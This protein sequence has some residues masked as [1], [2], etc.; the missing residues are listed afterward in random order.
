MSLPL[1]SPG[2]AQGR[3]N[4]DATLSKGTDALAAGD[5]LAAQGDFSEA[6]AAY[7]SG[8]SLQPKAI[9]L[10]RQKGSVLHAMGRIAEAL[11]IYDQLLDL[12]PT[13]IQALMGKGDALAAQQNP[14]ALESYGRA[15]GLR[16]N[17][18]G[19][20]RRNALAQRRFGLH[21]EALTTFQRA[22]EID[23]RDALSVRGKGDELLEL[24][25]YPEAF[26]AF[27]KTAE[28]VP[29]AMNGAEWSVRGEALLRA[30]KT[31]AALELFRIATSLEPSYVAAWS[32][33]ARAQNQNKQVAEALATLDRT[34]VNYPE[35]LNI[36]T[37]KGALLI[38]ERQFED[39]VSTYDAILRIDPV[40]WIGWANKG[41]ALHNLAR[42]EDANTCYDKALEL[43]PQNEEIWPFKGVCLEELGKPAE[44]LACY[45]HALKINPKSFV[46]LNNKGWLL[47]QQD[48]FELAL[49]LLDRAIEQNPTEQT[50]W[51]N[52]VFTLR[53]MG[54]IDEALACANEGIAGVED[55]RRLLNFSG[56]L[57]SDYKD[58]HEGA[59]AV[60]R[61]VTDLDPTSLDN[62]ACLAEVL[63]KLGRYAEGRILAEEIAELTEDP[64]LQSI[65][66]FFVLASFALEKNADRRQESFAQFL[67]A[68]QKLALSPTA[69]SRVWVFSG[70][71][72]C[73]LQSTIPA[74]TQFLLLSLIDLQTGAVKRE[75]VSYLKAHA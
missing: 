59:L 43:D 7:D 70:L 3:S 65:T 41:A 67:A 13:D 36:L 9:P 18:V 10:L 39:A 55:K 49:E 2:Q 8:L 35:N 19:I 50:P 11:V 22:L 31:Q 12:D 34:L 40:N 44:A 46:A 24:E 29:E 33:L 23:P 60:Y 21:N 6:L 26:D 47:A 5:R 62:R 57:L 73:I 28:L 48:S 72:R 42:Y 38:Q 37:E 68:F 54:K 14:A 51:L 30:Q 16:P 25:R 15:L 1:C 74:E 66:R 69:A 45:D 56:M 17:D 61:R 4:L 52:K 53:R 71:C 58:D 64:L 63:L 20:V 75:Q 27:R 32:G